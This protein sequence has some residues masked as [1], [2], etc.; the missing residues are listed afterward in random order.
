MISS[1]KS[2]NP[3][4]SPSKMSVEQKVLPISNFIKF[5]N[6]TSKSN[7]KSKENRRYGGATEDPTS[8]SPNRRQLPQ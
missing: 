5:E 2:K 3:E 1:S 8:H 7:S 6:S 4:T